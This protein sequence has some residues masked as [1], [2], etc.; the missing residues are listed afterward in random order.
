MTYYRALVEHCRTGTR[1][2]GGRGL[3]TEQATSS[4]VLRT[5]LLVHFTELHSLYL[6]Q[7][8]QQQSVHPLPNTTL[9][10][11][12]SQHMFSTKRLDIFPPLDRSFIDPFESQSGLFKSMNSNIKSDTELHR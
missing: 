1:L 11:M 3:F 9:Q 4:G 12:L 5:M 8:L 2:L 7:E 10:K 6:S